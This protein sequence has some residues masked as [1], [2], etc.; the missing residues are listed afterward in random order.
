[1]EKSQL[2]Q[3]NAGLENQKVNH[4]SNQGKRVMSKKNRTYKVI[5]LK[6]LNIITEPN[7]KLLIFNKL[8]F[9]FAFNNNLI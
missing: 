8:K 6:L 4:L 2:Q 1:M 9:K 3:K 7:A 5:Q